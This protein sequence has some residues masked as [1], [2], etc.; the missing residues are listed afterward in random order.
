MLG[1][2]PAAMSIAH[3]WQFCQFNIDYSRIQ[4]LEVKEL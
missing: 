3:P 2:G 1:M 4:I